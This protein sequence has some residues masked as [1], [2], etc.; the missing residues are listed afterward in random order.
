MDQRS[1]SIGLRTVG[2]WSFH[3][4]RTYDEPFADVHLDAHLTAPS[5]RTAIMPAFWDGGSIWRV[6]F[7]PDEVGTWQLRTIARVRDHGLERE[8]TFEVVTHESRGFVKATPATGWGF[9]F[10][11]GDPIFILGDT[12]YHL[13]GMA[14]VGI[15]VVPFMERRVSQGFD[16]LRVR[17]PVSPFHPP[18]G[19]NLWQTRSLWP[20]GGSPQA[21]RFDRID[22]DYFRTVDRV[23]RKAEDSVWD[24]S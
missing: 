10:E 5:G 12:V 17:V 21:P 8:L 15:E 11:N 14:H 22:I 13:F 6:R 7:N 9:S 18:H 16:L 24:S 3:A 20:W 1:E 23:I 2:E 4:E 19:H